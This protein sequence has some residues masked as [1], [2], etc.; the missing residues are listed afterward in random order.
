MSS[1]NRKNETDSDNVEQLDPH[2]PGILHG[3]LYLGEES[4]YMC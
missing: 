3:G 4:G 2:L 1:A